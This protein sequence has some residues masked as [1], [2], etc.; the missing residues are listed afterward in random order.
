M[1]VWGLN[2]SK[3]WIALAALMS[4]GAISIQAG[5]DDKSL[6][7]HDPI[8]LGAGPTPIAGCLVSSCHGSYSNTVP[9]WQRSGRIWLYD[10]PHARAYNTLWKPESREIVRRLLQS[11]SPISEDQH[12]AELNAKCISCHASEHA[13][14]Q[15]TLG[16][17]CQSCHGAANAWNESHYAK[18]IATSPERL[19][20]KSLANRVAICASCHVGEIG[21]SDGLDREVD[22]RIMAAGHP[23][24]HF[25]FEQFH[26]SYPTH[27]DTAK[28]AVSAGMS[29][30]RWRVGRLVT[31]SVRLKLLRGRA[32]RA[33]EARYYESHSTDRGEW[34]ELTE[35]SCYD[36]HHTLAQPSWRQQTKA[37]TGTYRW[38]PWCR[39]S[40]AV[41]LSNETTSSIEEE[42]SFIATTLEQSVP[43]T[44]ELIRR[45][46]HLESLIDRE[47][48]LAT[49]DAVPT[50]QALRGMLQVLAQ[51]SNAHQN[52][53]SA[54]QWNG[55]VR[56]IVG[57]L[58]D[59]I[60]LNIPVGLQSDRFYGDYQ[61]WSPM[62]KRYQ[63]RKNASA[64]FDPTWIDHLQNQLSSRLGTPP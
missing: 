37:M 21:R 62:D 61:H 10:D 49:T 41:A 26:Q 51:D 32:Q 35:H 16:V 39:A 43:E 20:T 22:H 63:H 38:D 15:P 50:Q 30:Q 9:M 3:G 56:S 54:T 33:H 58:Q 64:R 36:C 31:L 28:D 57:S 40:L 18:T 34:P 44:T 24:I 23:A 4:V 12:R 25:E 55:A 42:L 52:W 8:E 53:E 6:H 11:E 45:I 14:T 13:S 1:I 2:R 5:A 17:D 7:P 59:P 48:T 19:D 60:S 29:Y 27:W 46:D 47:C